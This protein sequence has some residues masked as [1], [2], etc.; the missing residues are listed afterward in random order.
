LNDQNEVV[1]IY[2]GL[3]PNPRNGE[4]TGTAHAVKDIQASLELAKVKVKSVEP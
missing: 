4:P 1:G 2:V 3:L